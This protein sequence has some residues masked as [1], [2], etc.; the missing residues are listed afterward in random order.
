MNCLPSDNS[1]LRVADPAQDRVKDKAS[2]CREGFTAAT[3]LELPQTVVAGG[4]GA[5]AALK[6][7][8]AGAPDPPD[9]ILGPVFN[10]SPVHPLLHNS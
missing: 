3:A 7:S 1:R 6:L 10:I 4:G 2:G 5:T 8:Q 9:P